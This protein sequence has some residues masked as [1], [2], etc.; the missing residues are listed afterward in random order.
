MQSSFSVPLVNA[1]EFE[2]DVRTEQLDRAIYDLLQ[3]LKL[4]QSVVELRRNAL[5]QT[6]VHSEAVG[7]TRYTSEEAEQLTI[8]ILAANESYTPAG[9]RIMVSLAVSD[10]KNLLE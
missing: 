8:Q 2:A 4:P 6:L 5:A 9:K 1:K 10:I 7:K 3:S